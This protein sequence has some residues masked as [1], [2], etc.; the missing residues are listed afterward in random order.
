M[1]KFLILAL[2]ALASHAWANGNITSLSTGKGSGNSVT[3]DDPNGNTTN[4]ML[5]VCPACPGGSSGSSVSVTAILG[6]TTLP[7]PV[8]CTGCAG[9]VGTPAYVVLAAGSQSVTAQLAISGN[10]VASNNPVPVTWTGVPVGT[11]ADPQYVNINSPKLTDSSTNTKVAVSIS[12]L[13]HANTEINL[14]YLSP[15]AANSEKFVYLTPSAI[16]SVTVGNVGSGAGTV[17]VAFTNSATYVSPSTW[18]IPCVPGVCNFTNI[19]GTFLHYTN[20]NALTVTSA[21]YDWL[22]P[23]ISGTSLPQTAPFN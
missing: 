2:L 3:F 9:T 1:K 12:P 6:Q 10:L 18:G 22:T 7:L 5:V 16:M 19:S 15:T 13:I 23:A 11:V 20:A 14:G 17:Y 4:G 21:N 8:A